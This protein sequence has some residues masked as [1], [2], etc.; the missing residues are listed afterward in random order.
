MPR[1]EADPFVDLVIRH[2]QSG[3]LEVL[4]PDGD[5]AWALAAIDNARDALKRKLLRDGRLIVPPE[6]VS[7]T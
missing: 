2:H 4:Y 1:E 6:D 7:L 3:A 5:L